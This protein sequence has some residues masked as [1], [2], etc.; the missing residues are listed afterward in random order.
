MPRPS[1]RR[2]L[3]P[4][5]LS[6]LASYALVPVV[7]LSAGGAWLRLTDGDWRRP[8]LGVLLT[9]LASALGVVA[10]AVKARASAILMVFSPRPVRAIAIVSLIAGLLAMLL[11]CVI[12]S[13]AA[14]DDRLWRN[15][16]GEAAIGG[17]LSLGLAGF[18]TLFWAFG[19]DYLGERIE[20]RAG[21]EW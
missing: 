4:G 18:F 5:Q 17:G 20:D 6:H 3:G 8:G 12:A 11:G 16:I 2:R 19:L 9:I 21:E 15:V 1:R 13:G 7:A 10:A 14:R